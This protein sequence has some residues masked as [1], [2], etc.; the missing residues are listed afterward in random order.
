MRSLK[1][2]DSVR[3]VHAKPMA[4]PRS[5]TRMRRA[6]VV[7]ILAGVL[8]PLA[9]VVLSGGSAD[10]ISL[11]NRKP[12]I[13]L[14]SGAASRN[15]VVTGA[16]PGCGSNCSGQNFSGANLSGQDLSGVNFTNANLSSANLSNA[17]LS[18]ANLANADLSNANLTGANLTGANLTGTQTSGVTWSNATCPD[19][20]A[21]NTVG[22]WHHVVGTVG[23]AG[24]NVF[25]D[26]ALMA[27]NTTTVGE[28]FASYFLFGGSADAN[29]TGKSARI[30]HAAVF[31]NQLTLS[32]VKALYGVR[33]STT[34][35]SRLVNSLNPLF[36][37]PLDN[38]T[39][40][41]AGGSLGNGVLGNSTG[42]S[43]QS[44]TTV[45]PTRSGS[46]LFTNSRVSSSTPYTLSN[47]SAYSM[48]F[49]FQ[50]NSGYQALTRVSPLSAS[51]GYSGQGTGVL[52]YTPSGYIGL[53]QPNA[54]TGG[55]SYVR[56]NTTYASGSTPS[57]VTN[58]A[59]SM[60]GTFVGPGADLQNVNFGSANLSNR[61]LSW[62]NISGAN[63][64]G[65]NLTGVIASNV[66]SSSTTRL[67]FGWSVNNGFLV[68][69]GANLSNADLTGMDLSG[70]N[71][72]NAN[73][74]AATFSG[75]TLR[76]ANVTNANFSS[77]S[78]SGLI[79]GGLIGTAGTLPTGWTQQA[80]WFL[81][82][83][84]NLTGM[85]LTGT[86]LT[87]LNLSGA[88]LTNALLTNVNLTNVNLSN[89]NLKNTKLSGVNLSGT[90]LTGTTTT[91]GITGTSL[92]SNAQTTL[93]STDWKIVGGV[94]IGPGANLK[95]VNLSSLNLSNTKLNGATLT[96]ANI[97]GTNFTGANLTNVLSGSLQSSSA[98]T[99]PSGWSLVSGYLVGQ[100]ANLT[101]L[102]VSPP[103]T[104]VSAAALSA[105][106]T[107]VRVA[108]ASAFPQSGTFSIQID[109]EIMNVTAGAGSTTWTVSRGSS[110]TT[111]AAH[112]IGAS[113]VRTTGINLSNA[114]MRD[115]NLA[116]A[117]LAYANLGDANLNG[118]KLTNANL[119]GARMNSG[120]SLYQTVL[121]GATLR[122]A[123]LSGVNFSNVI[124]TATVGSSTVNGANFAGASVTS[125]YFGSLSL[126]TSNITGIRSGSVSGTPVLPTGWFVSQGYLVGPSANLSGLN[127]TGMSFAGVTGLS[128]VNMSNS[129]LTNV[130]FS[131]ASLLGFNLSGANLTGTNFTNANL[132]GVISGS[133]TSTSAPTLPASWTITSG[134]LIGPGAN[135]SGASLASINLSNRALNTTNFSNATLTNANFSGAILTSGIFTSTNLSNANLSTAWLKDANLTSA[136]LT[137]ANL[138]SVKFLG[139]TLT[140]TNLSGATL[141]SVS[142]GAVV[143]TSAPT[144]PSG[145]GLVA[146][147][148]LGSTADLTNATL[149][150]ANLGTYNLS[151]AT[152][153][154]VKSGSLTGSPTLPS[155]FSM[156]GGYLVGP[157][158]D[159]TNANLSNRNL[160]TLSLNGTILKGAS[161][162][163]ANLSANTLTGVI[164]GSLTSTP[165]LPTGYSVKGGY[166]VGPGVNLTNANFPQVGLSK[167][168]FTNV[169][170][171]GATL[172]G[173]NLS[174][175]IMDGVKSGS[176][177]GFPV[178]PS[179]WTVSN[180]Y[181][182][183]KKADLTDANISG[184][185]L[186]GF[187]LQQTKFNN[188]SVRG[189]NFTNANLTSAN[190]TGANLGPISVT[191][192]LT[193]AIN[194]SQ[195]TLTVNSSSG[196]PSRGT[197][198]ILVG[199]EKMTVT[200]GNGTTSWTVTRG[201]YAT[202]SAAQSS[203]ATVTLQ[204]AGA[205]LTGA[206][207]TATNLTNSTLNGVTSSGI[208]VSGSNPTLPTSWTLIEGG[209]LVGPGSNLSGKTMTG[210]NF[211]G[212]NF[213]QVILVGA[214]L[215][216]SNMS[217]ANLTN[218]SVTSAVVDGTNLSGATLTGLAS[219]GV[220]G[221]PT[222][223]SGYKL[224]NGFILGQ[225]LDLR[226]AI[227]QNQNLE[228][229][230]LSSSNLSGANLNGATVS[231]STTLTSTNLSN[232]SLQSA[233]FSGAN[234][235]SANL[236]GTS[237]SGT[238]LSSATLGSSTTVSNS[239]S[240]A[241]ANLFGASINGLG[242]STVGSGNLSG[243]MSGSITGTPS[244]PSGWWT[245]PS[246]GYLVGS[247][248]NLQNAN[249]EGITF[250][251]PN[252]SGVDLQNASF[253]GAI[254]PSAN[255]ANADL[256]GA[257]LQGAQLKNA[258][259]SSAT[260]SA[261]DMSYAGISQIKLPSTV[262]QLNTIGVNFCTANYVFSSS[263]A[264]W[265]GTGSGTC[266]SWNV[267][268][269]LPS[270]WQIFDG[271]ASNAR[272]FLAGPGASL[273][274]AD[275]SNWNMSGVQLQ[276][277]SSGFLKA[278]PTAL[279]TDW[280]CRSVGTK[281]DFVANDGSN[282]NYWL[283]GPSV[284][285]SSQDFTQLTSPTLANAYVVGA[286]MA[287]SDFS[288]ADFTGIN[289]GDSVDLTNTNLNGTWLNGAYIRNL[290]S[291][292]GL[293]LAGDYSIV[294]RPSD[295]SNGPANVLAG[296][297][298]SL[299]GFDLSGWDFSGK[300][301]NWAF[302]ENANL[303][304]TNF[305]NANLRN[306]R[307]GGSTFTNTNLT[308]TSMG[309]ASQGS[310]S[311]A[312]LNWGSTNNTS[313]TVTSPFDTTCPEGLVLG[314]FT[315][316]KNNNAG[317]QA[318]GMVCYPVTAEGNSTGTGNQTLHVKD[319]YQNG[320]WW[321]GCGDG[322]LA[323]GLQAYDSD[324][325][326]KNIGPI[327]A[328]FPSATGAYAPN[329][330]LQNST[331]L[332]NSTAL[333]GKHGN[334]SYICPTGQWLVGI[335]AQ[336]SSDRVH[337]INQA[338]CQ[339]W[340]LQ[341]ASGFVS[342]GGI[343]GQ[344]NLS[345]GWKV[346]NGFLVGPG[347]N[348][349]NKDLSG[350][351]LS[352]VNL[353]D[354]N[355]AGTN[356]TNANL[357]YVRSNGITGSPTLPSGYGIRRGHLL[358]PKV[359]LHGAN[360]DNESF[361]EWNMSGASFVNT[362]LYNVNFSNATLSNAFFGH[363]STDMRYV[364]FSSASLTGA[365]MS[366]RSYNVGQ[367]LSSANATNALFIRTDL[368][369]GNISVASTTLYQTN[370]TGATIANSGLTGNFRTVTFSN[371]SRDLGSGNYTY[372][373][374]RFATGKS[375]DSSGRI[376]P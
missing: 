78:P 234:L 322:E 314:Q 82:Q 218:A 213:S 338:I 203:G 207:M 205:N 3:Q 116:G 35:Q 264:T 235:S 191:T 39:T 22:T 193:G 224:Q 84:A 161:L 69:P 349:A 27:S 339:S 312:D 202:S 110:G 169:S 32:Q 332:Y 133:V 350:A 230:N 283:L 4:T 114:D 50:A 368:D 181:L 211:S 197:F 16:A 259:L 2:F 58:L 154:G 135:L 85:Q 231:S 267:S 168:N 130:N 30:A 232:A 288:T 90:T 369:G 174:M 236:S 313:Y 348:L 44:S 311:R 117:N 302:I 71:V 175:T 296:P 29:A 324:R 327:C 12:S 93:P 194:S 158:A 252:F 281:S 92:T 299:Y 129:N 89:A 132:N 305:A 318:L 33:A 64:S 26:G 125:A 279:P 306:A 177:T 265:S 307:L 298:V 53:Y 68:G 8:L 316:S 73:F 295:R 189:V 38:G 171:Q 184:A 242:L 15:L 137:G 172:T 228:N 337:K 275:L 343:V 102:S 297:M 165:T 285:L 124:L 341:T 152:L 360:L 142:S 291:T 317:L 329:M 208:T 344:P 375:V 215:S 353:G 105:S 271:G 17:N 36:Y 56:T 233:N 282:N 195:G 372:D 276:N 187:D 239:T 88:N 201:Q 300:N 43:A 140:S 63:L 222:L 280:V 18:L 104:A 28:G 25:V 11:S 286:N 109:D 47:T 100:G 97:S 96:G 241:N 113:V 66:T 112:I 227:L 164:S 186:T 289:L 247:G 19:G 325:S 61:D 277:V 103:R 143:A 206:T 243:L 219:G 77:T 212:V 48:S 355:L 303:T 320:Q 185:D 139:A 366:Y 323:I 287:G 258:D 245:T 80:G 24:M 365:D 67:P 72:S 75:T 345:F 20:A 214:N 315:T 34:G 83:N 272:S 210:R 120:T 253:F 284:D 76:R 107:T 216:N 98:P 336:T 111:A 370:F 121:A 167:T 328:K 60:N 160:S 351:N 249:L 358:G 220:S 14:A 237:L 204:Q 250:S 199:S 51:Q 13:L 149:T 74:T 166:I 262:K 151:S 352:G 301:L 263:T 221:T 266:T 156:I 270:N 326:I 321:K 153:T 248:A 141:T 274:G 347:V 356:L 70:A 331:E 256:S 294:S 95:N 304:G 226:G 180:G 183:G 41:A 91:T 255:F 150:S 99:L 5:S 57:C 55:N 354:A 364:N 21:A 292:T 363:Y 101:N 31:P 163:G 155:S 225:S 182:I 217:N 81:G 49:W 159:L 362:N 106:S 23:P 308:N 46:Y 173:T 290:S 310:Y 147:N 333:Q 261:V 346:V 273:Y 223:S 254:L 190:F 127:L 115:V 269:Q 144:F 200:A 257:N 176:V 86:D 330:V 209:F 240:F 342:G 367:N 65:A 42:G 134:Y 340:N 54:V 62:A 45:G 122:S 7:A 268:A 1:S 373:T 10:A 357:D 192:T 118:A 148:I 238:N 37:L 260:V 178:L 146:G 79:T 319:M 371:P 293:Q 6:G 244:L 278:C 376:I 229:L 359:S 374:Q 131:N 108:S 94:L 188:A 9:T 196:F 126:S 40:N 246:G 251:S 162:G 123:N 52:E 128:G 138:T 309:M 87:G 198:I 179:G 361:T 335:Q 170:L 334:K 119:T 59:A 145:W 157:G 136:N